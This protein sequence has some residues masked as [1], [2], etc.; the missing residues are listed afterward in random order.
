MNPAIAESI[1]QLTAAK[2]AYDAA[3]KAAG[4]PLTKW[5]QELITTTPRLTCITWRQYTPYFNNDDECTFKVYTPTF[6]FDE[7]DAEELDYR[8]GLSFNYKRFSK[9]NNSIFNKALG[10][11]PESDYSTCQEAC[12]TI[13]K[14]DDVLREAFGDHV[15][16]FVTAGGIKIESIDHD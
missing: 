1:A 15:E 14:L 12:V 9:N 7:I 10:A 5:L 2:D 8:D 16:I 3:T 6:V 11:P 13:E 4:E